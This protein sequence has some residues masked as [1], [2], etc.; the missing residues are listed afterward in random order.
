MTIYP[1]FAD[2][3]HEAIKQ[4]I[5]ISQQNLHGALVAKQKGDSIFTEKEVHIFT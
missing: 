3:K 1:F 5:S 2:D 4:S